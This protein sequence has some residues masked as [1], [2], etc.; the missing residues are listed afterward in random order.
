MLTRE[1]K[2][3]LFGTA[4]R[5]TVIE[6]G[7]VSDTEF[8]EVR[9]KGDEE[10]TRKIKSG[11]EA[12]RAEDIAGTIDWVLGQPAHVNINSIE[13]MPVAQAPGGLVYDRKSG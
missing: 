12:L 11:V 4:V 2:A 7:M 13:L 8:T 9:V 1:L 10:M 5:V 6:P 3:D